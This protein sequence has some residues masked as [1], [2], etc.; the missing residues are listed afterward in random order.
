MSLRT[1]HLGI[2]PWPGHRANKPGLREKQRMETQNLRV[3]PYVIGLFRA[4]AQKD[5]Q[6]KEISD[7]LMALGDRSM[8]LYMS[9]YPS[10]RLYVGASSVSQI[11][12]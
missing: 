10:I 11:L 7:H 9:P 2:R 3:V 6:G 5:K 8:H 4:A 1:R 12:P